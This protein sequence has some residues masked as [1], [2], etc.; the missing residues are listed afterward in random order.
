MFS[1]L[2]RVVWPVKCAMLLESWEEEKLRICREL[3]TLSGAK[4]VDAAKL[5]VKPG[6]HIIALIA[7]KSAQATRTILWKQQQKIWE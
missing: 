3:F 4:Q 2:L 6:F 5:S 7:R 1:Q